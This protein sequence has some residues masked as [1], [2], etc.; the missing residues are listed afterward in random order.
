MK[1]ISSK[2]FQPSSIAGAVLLFFLL[3]VAPGCQKLLD[4][5]PGHEQPPKMVGEFKQVNLV[6][7]KEGYGATRIDPLLINAWGIAFS[8]GGT[9]WIGSQGGHVSPV[10]NSEGAQARPPVNIPSP[11]GPTGGNPTGVAFYG[12]N[13]DFILANGQAARF[14]FVGVDGILSAWNGAAGNNALLIKNNVATAVYT[15]LAIA[16]DGGNNFLYAANFAARTI[17]VFDRTFTPVTN[18]PFNDP[19]LP[20]DYSPF[21][22]TAIGDK[23]YVMY[24]KVGADGRDE[25]GIGKGIVNIYSTSGVLL[26]RFAAKGQLNA[27][28]G[29]A[30][31][32]PNFF[33][34]NNTGD[35]ENAILI[36]NFGDGR[37]LAYASDGSYLGYLRMNNKPVEIEGLWEIRFAPTTSTV[38]QNRLYFAAGPNKEADGLFGYLINPFVGQ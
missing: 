14:I 33:D 22:I 25:K 16:S 28:W 24:A 8:S 36:G 17:D 27:P 9:P 18:K 31:A 30:Q 38:D 12:G 4:Q 15:G 2:I 5:L 35:D 37:I 32:T 6:A 34:T 10:Y 23:L 29:A 21:N 1:K 13:T 3:I 26:K 19:Y 7:N 11:G 20:T